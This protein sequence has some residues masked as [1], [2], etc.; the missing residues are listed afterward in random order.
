MQTRSSNQGTAGIPT[1]A[2]CHSDVVNTL[3]VL[4]WALSVMST[5]NLIMSDQQ[6]LAGLGS[7]ELRAAQAGDKAASF[8]FQN[9]SPL[10][11]VS[12]T[13]IFSGTPN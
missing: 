5:P 12:E 13:W 1:G 2:A 8:P 6:Q 11:Q 4:D 9:N 10:D 7:T 3:A